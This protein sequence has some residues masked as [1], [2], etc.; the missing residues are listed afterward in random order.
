MPARRTLRLRFTALTAAPPGHVGRVLLIA[1][2]VGC[3][4]SVYQQ[5]LLL[6]VWHPAYR[7]TLT[8]R[9]K[10]ANLYF[11]DISS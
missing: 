2:I 8:Q 7:Y 6:K 1:D 10:S 11:H 9:E 4:P 3:F 5:M